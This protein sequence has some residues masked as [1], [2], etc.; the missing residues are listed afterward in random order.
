MTLS[1]SFH[2]QMREVL[3][4]FGDYRAAR[5]KSKLRCL[6]KTSGTGDY[7][8]ASL[9]AEGL[10][11]REPHVRHLKDVLRCTLVLADHTAL[12]RAHAALLAK[13]TAVGTKDRRLL[14]PRDVLQ[15]VWFEGVIVEVQFH[16]AA[17]LALKVFSHAAYNISRVQTADLMGIDQLFNYPGIHLEATKPEDVTSKLHL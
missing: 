8:K 15:T 4:S 11:A 14:P 5:M 12:G 13:F 6:A 7:G 10:D 16:F 1:A 2:T 9:A 17:P 3:S